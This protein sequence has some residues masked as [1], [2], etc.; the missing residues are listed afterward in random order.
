MRKNNN[1][2][3]EIRNHKWNGST[4]YELEK[5]KD[6]G[7]GWKSQCGSWQYVNDI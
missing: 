1:Q 6:G 7:P 4:E 5:V 2:K 3:R